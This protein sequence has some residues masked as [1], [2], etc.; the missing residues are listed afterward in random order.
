[1]APVPNGITLE[2]LDC[3]ARR[4]GIRSTQEFEYFTNLIQ[5]MDAEYRSHVAKQTEK[6]R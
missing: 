3:Y 1:M 4:W 6:K 5:A 2:A